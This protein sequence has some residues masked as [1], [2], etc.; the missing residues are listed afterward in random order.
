M[1]SLTTMMSLIGTQAALGQA[2]Q[3]PLTNMQRL[4]T[5]LRDGFS[6]TSPAV[7][8]TLG[9]LNSDERPQANQLIETHNRHLQ[10]L[11]TTINGIISQEGG[12]IPAIEPL[13]QRDSIQE[14]INN[15]NGTISAQHVRNIHRQLVDAQPVFPSLWQIN[16]WN[17][18][19][20]YNR[21]SMGLGAWLRGN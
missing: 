9:R 18:C 13:L 5:L 16:Q 1:T 21:M 6:S 14:L 2:P 11:R 15:P 12:T 8:E 17:P 4:R 20:P 10:H 7:Q 19:N 3:P